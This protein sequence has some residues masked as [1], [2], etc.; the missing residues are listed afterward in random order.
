MHGIHFRK[1][2]DLTGFSLS[3]KLDGLRIE[4]RNSRPWSKQGQ[5]LRLPDHILLALMAL[6]DLDGELYVKPGCRAKLAGL[7]QSLRDDPQWP[8]DTCLYVFDSVKPLSSILPAGIRLVP[9]F[10]LAE[11]TGHSLALASAIISAGGEGVMARAP[12]LP[13]TDKRL[14]GLVKIKARSLDL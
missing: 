14:A 8:A 13:W 3:E 4:I 9:S 5:P 11:S 10:G 6:P 7:A 2:A 1:G 12:G